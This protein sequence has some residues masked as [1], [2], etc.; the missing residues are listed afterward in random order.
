ML[1][2]PLI[3]GC[4]DVGLDLVVLQNLRALQRWGVGHNGLSGMC[5]RREA[6]SLIG[7]TFGWISPSF[8]EHRRPGSAIYFGGERRPNRVI[9]NQGSI[10]ID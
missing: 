5:R 2:H 10:Q 3:N 1:I 4:I 6:M 7:T 8:N 9:G